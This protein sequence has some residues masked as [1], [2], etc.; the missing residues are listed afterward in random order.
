MNKIIPILTFD[1]VPSTQK[2]MYTSRNFNFEKDLELKGKYCNH[3]Y[4]TITIDS[5]GLIF[6]CICHA[7]LPISVGNILDFNSL[8]EI[9]DNAISQNIVSSIEDGSYRYCD[10][11]SCGLIISDIL[12]TQKPSMDSIL[13]N[14]AMDE[15]CNL[16]CPSCRTK[17]KFINEEHPK[18]TDKLK[19]INHLL[20]LINKSKIKV[21]VSLAGDGDPF[22]SLLYRHFISNLDNNNLE[23][24]INTNGILIKDFW[25]K[26]EKIHNNI[27][28]LKISIDAGSKDTYEIVRRGGSWS[29]L[30][31]SI[32]FISSWRQNHKS[33]FKLIGNFVL[34]SRNFTDIIKYVNLCLNYNF[35]EINFQKIQDW[36]T[37]LQD[38]EELEVWKQNNVNFEDFVNI[39]LNP[40]L[41][42]PK[43][44][45]TNL[46]N[47]YDEITRTS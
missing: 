34:Q 17:M 3:V 10:N 19:I 11:N 36:N 44:N 14:L 38:F 24:E 8:D 16:T 27:V 2:W 41:K 28:R 35:D 20:D 1:N 23:V 18:Y 5:D 33:N 29:K 30:L 37:Y 4:R 12:M 47:I 22:A 13:V 26:L 32:D 21:I 45:F 15:S 31:E 39:L 9:L 6:R 42:N 25:N 7:W 46:Q 40:V 43:I